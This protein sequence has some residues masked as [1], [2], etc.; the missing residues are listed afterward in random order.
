MARPGARLVAPRGAR[1]AL[2]ML[3]GVA[4]FG[5]LEAPCRAAPP[6]AGSPFRYDDHPTPYADAAGLYARLKYIPLGDGSYASFGADLRER[7]EATDGT[8]LGLGTRRSDLYDLHRLLVFGDLQFGPH[9]RAFVQLGDHDEAGRSPGPAPLDVDRL[10]LAQAFV[11]VAGE[12]AGGHAVLRVGRAEMSFDDGALIGLRDGPNVRQVWDGGRLSYVAGAWRW[13]AFAVRPVA[14]KPGVFDDGTL[15]GQ[16]LEGVH[17]TVAPPGAV[18]AD[19]FVY[20]DLMP[21]AALF[22]AAGKERTDTFGLRLRAH[23]GAFDGSAG[24]IGQTGEAAGRTVRAFALHADGGVSLPRVPWAPHL[25]LRADVLS[26]GDPKA[27]HVST[28]N[29]LYP[30][31]AY[32]TEATIEAP[33]NLIQ[34]GLVLSATPLPALSLQYTVE[35]LWRFSSKDAFYAAP[36]FPLVQPDGS[37]DRYSGLEQQLRGVWRIGPHVTLTSALVHFSAG[38]FIRR[39]G[40]RDQ[41][42]GMTSLALRL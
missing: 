17:L 14:V 12:A 41:T 30:N 36:L 35:G 27:G 9:L 18:A 2:E 38:D 32:S 29:A 24:A 22:G 42:F 26:G 4:L 25:S 10:D 3:V 11:D 19:A 16:S 1:A 8:F 37:G 5:L 39:G 15:P 33:A 31:V 13:D 40:G 23:A 20:H 21:Q 7:V 28:F 6:S 34:S